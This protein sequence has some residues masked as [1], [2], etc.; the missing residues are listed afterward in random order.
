[1]GLGSGF[2]AHVLATLMVCWRRML[3]VGA[4]VALVTALAV[5]L[6]GFTVSHQFPPSLAT[7]LLAVALAL[8]L[9]YG[10]GATIFADEVVRGAL[11]ALTLLQTQ[12]SGQRLAMELPTEAAA[13]L[14]TPL[15]AYWSRSTDPRADSSNPMVSSGASADRP[16]IRPVQQPSYVPIAPQVATSLPVS[17]WSRHF[18]P[19]APLDPLPAAPPA[20]LEPAPAAAYAPRL[21][22]PLIAG[23]EPFRAVE[24]DATKPATIY[25]EDGASV[26]LLPDNSWYA[27]RFAQ[28]PQQRSSAPMPIG[29]APGAQSAAMRVQRGELWAAQSLYD[30]L[31][32]ALPPLA[33]AAPVSPPPELYAPWSVVP[34]LDPAISPTGRTELDPQFAGRRASGAK[35]EPRGLLG[36]IFWPRPARE[37]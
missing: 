23:R 8:A 24:E 18:M 3:R 1:M 4:A 33:G 9:G 14:P 32:G 16:A 13:A 2:F 27:P 26:L 22:D 25:E 17:E 29:A 15:P 10:V 30:G 28:Q 11:R 12:A 21:S 35:P 19:V 31:P 5:E 37:S 7:N 36:R 20:G 6:L 34:P